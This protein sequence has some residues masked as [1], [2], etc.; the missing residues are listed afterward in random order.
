MLPCA[1]L[2]ANLMSR[3]PAEAGPAAPTPTLT[4]SIDG[5]EAEHVSIAEPPAGAGRWTPP[6]L[7]PAGAGGAD[8][9]VFR[10]R[11]SAA[12]RLL[13][14]RVSSRAVLAGAQSHQ[15]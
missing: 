14:S 5:F 3:I 10:W 15:S 13:L 12:S 11:I 7:D 9:H 1:L 6:V 2:I 4:A 8:G